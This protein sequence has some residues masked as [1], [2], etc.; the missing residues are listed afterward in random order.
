MSRSRPTRSSPVSQ[1]PKRVNCVLYMDYPA[2]ELVDYAE[3]WRK[4][5][6]PVQFRY[7]YTETTPENLYQEEGDKILADLKKRF[8]YKGLDGAACATATTSITR[9]CT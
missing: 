8:T 4:Y 3:R 9:A 6:I 1:R 5:N 2:D 7:D